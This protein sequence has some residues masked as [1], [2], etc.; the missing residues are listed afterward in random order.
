MVGFQGGMEREKER[1]GCGSPCENQNQ[2]LKL[3]RFHLQRRE[4]PDGTTKTV[5]TDGRQETHYASGRV[6]VKDANGAVVMD[7]W[8][9]TA[10]SP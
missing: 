7:T 4:C 8:S 3:C 5:F 9:T 1:E 10:T 6:R 2:F